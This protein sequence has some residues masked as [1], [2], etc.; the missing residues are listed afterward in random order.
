MQTQR[1]RFQP[2]LENYLRPR[3]PELEAPLMAA[4]DAFDAVLQTGEL[5]PE[6]LRPIVDAVSSSR[7]PLY[8]NAS[9]FMGTPITAAVSRTRFVFFLA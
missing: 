8:E 5:L 6:R 3:Y 9:G 1:D 4:V 2:W 7:G